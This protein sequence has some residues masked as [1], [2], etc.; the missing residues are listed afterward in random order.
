MK[1]EWR[2]KHPHWSRWLA[3]EFEEWERS[4][5][6]AMI[7]RLGGVGFTDSGIRAPAYEGI[8]EVALSRSGSGPFGMWDGAE[9]EEFIRDAETVIGR[10]PRYRRMNPSELL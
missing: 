1:F 6:E 8:Q 4:S 3:I 10:R 5:A 7:L 9:S 2:S